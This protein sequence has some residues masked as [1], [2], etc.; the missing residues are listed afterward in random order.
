[1]SGATVSDRPEVIARAEQALAMRSIESAV[2]RLYDATYPYQ[3][4]RPSGA[5]V[6]ATLTA[7]RVL[8]DDQMY[9]PIVRIALGVDA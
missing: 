6:D 1:V 2:R 9:G 8:L 3:G 5:Q 7:I 4:D